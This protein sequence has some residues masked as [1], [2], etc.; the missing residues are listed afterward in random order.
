MSQPER[1][2]LGANWKRRPRRTRRN[3][4]SMTRVQSG[5][6]WTTGTWTSRSQNQA[7]R[8]GKRRKRTKV[9]KLVRSWSPWMTSTTVMARAGMSV[10]SITHRWDLGSSRPQRSHRL[11]CR[12]DHRHRVVHHRLHLQAQDLHSNSQHQRRCRP[13]HWRRHRVRVRHRW[14]GRQ[15]QLARHHQCLDLL[16]HH[17]H[18]RHLPLPVH[19]LHR[20]RC[21][22]SPCQFNGQC[23]IMLYS[24]RRMA[25]MPFMT[26]C[27]SQW[28]TR[29][30]CSPRGA[31]LVAWASRGA[32]TT[33]QP[34]W[35]LGRASAR[36]WVCRP[37]RQQTNRCQGG[38][39]SISRL[40]LNQ[41]TQ[42]H[43]KCS[44]RVG[45]HQRS[46]QSHLRESLNRARRSNNR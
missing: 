20:L 46:I 22:S 12:R 27:S 25:L 32:A 9:W 15:C 6:S 39:S 10:S 8:M 34:R 31:T 45:R 16:D 11:L 37:T 44:R 7:Q 19:P 43:C 23:H 42:R 24:C 35:A 41:G 26:P 29:N 2:L 33:S 30:L 14:R 4:K 28:R 40:K 13:L 17:Q 38:N 1:G 18:H 36:A 5:L 21:C 3:L